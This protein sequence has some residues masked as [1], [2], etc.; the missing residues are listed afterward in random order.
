MENDK[1]S[2]L[3]ATMRGLTNVQ[4]CLAPELRLAIDSDSRKKSPLVLVVEDYSD[5]RE[6][7][8]VM[9]NT[10]GYEVIE[11]QDGVQAVELAIQFRPD[12][13]LLDINLPLMDGFQAA[14][15]I[16]RQPET[17]NIPII[18]CTAH[19]QASWRKKAQES[20]CNDFLRKPVDFNEL[21]LLLKRYSPL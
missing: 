7:M 11:A 3:E 10:L 8:C 13:I 2:P 12:L 17:S 15:L 9:L 19:S 14:S 1:I 6:M 20:G 4:D 5:A 21:E 16:R 18:A